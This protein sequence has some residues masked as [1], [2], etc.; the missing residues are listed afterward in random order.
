MNA[1]GPRLAGLYVILGHAGALGRLEAC[2]DAGVRLFQYRGKAEATLETA[3][4]LVERC[5]AAGALLIVNDDLGLALAAGAHGL[6]L[7]QEDAERL[8]MAEVRRRLGSAVL[9]L[10]THDGDQARRA[11]ALGASYVGAGCTFPTQ[12]KK[13]VVEIGLEGLRRIVEASPVPVAA[14]GGI[15]VENVAAVRRAGAAMAAVIGAV[16]HAGDTRAAALRLV[17]AWNGRA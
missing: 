2:L 3:R 1:L 15:N 12:S 4:A 9:G 16:G 11:A 17:D 13:Y 10:S 8:D 7:G 5:R 6:H 14:I